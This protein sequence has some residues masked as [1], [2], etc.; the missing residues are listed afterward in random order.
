MAVK[1]YMTAIKPSEATEHTIVL[2]QTNTRRTNS[3]ASKAESS[4]RGILLYKLGR[5]LGR[6]PNQRDLF[7]NREL[8]TPKKPR[9]Q[10]RAMVQAALDAM[11]PMAVE[12]GSQDQ[13]LSV[14]LERTFANRR[15]GFACMRSIFENS[16]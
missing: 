14:P 12:T 16:D 15:A 7:K 5:Y 13:G 11:A 2:A 3:A 6:L 4:E 9:N 10:Q 8:I 1:A